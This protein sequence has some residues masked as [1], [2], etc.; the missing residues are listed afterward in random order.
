MEAT[1][2]PWGTEAHG[3]A[4]ARSQGATCIYEG[5][6]LRNHQE[7]AAEARKALDVSRPVTALEVL[8][9]IGSQPGGELESCIPPL[10]AV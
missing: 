10:L 7:V 2:P 1:L 9:G 5:H 6:L 4:E 3:R 8:G